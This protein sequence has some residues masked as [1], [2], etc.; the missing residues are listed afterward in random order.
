MVLYGDNIKP[1]DEIEVLV[2]TENY[3]NELET[4]RRLIEVTVYDENDICL[5]ERGLDNFS[6]VRLS[7]FN[8][9]AKDPAKPK[10]IQSDIWK[11]TIYTSGKIHIGQVK[12]TE[13]HS[14]YTGAK[15]TVKPE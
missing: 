3:V 4:K 9:N 14:E 6:R 2:N 7:G 8:S 11:Y 15:Y 12:C 5:L 1:D 13:L 10:E